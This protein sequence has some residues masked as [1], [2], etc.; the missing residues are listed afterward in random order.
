MTATGRVVLRRKN[1]TCAPISGENK[2]IKI[3]FRNRGNPKVL[4]KTKEKKRNENFGI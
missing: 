2:Y 1:V 3:I 4:S